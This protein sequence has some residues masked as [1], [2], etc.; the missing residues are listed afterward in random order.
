M[1]LLVNYTYKPYRIVEIL[2]VKLHNANTSF[3]IKS[4]WFLQKEVIYQEERNEICRNYCKM[5]AILL[6]L[7]TIIKT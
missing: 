1:A 3:A 5:T 2:K 4:V 6:N 7:P